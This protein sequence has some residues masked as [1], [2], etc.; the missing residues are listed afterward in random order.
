MYFEKINLPLFT[1]NYLSL[2][3]T[4]ANLEF[5]KKSKLVKKEVELIITLDNS[6]LVIDLNSFTIEPLVI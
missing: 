4:G 5:N 1:E 3:K 6:L 2:Y